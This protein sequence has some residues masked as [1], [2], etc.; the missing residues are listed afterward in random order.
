[1]RNRINA[2]VVIE[3]VVPACVSAVAALFCGSA[4]AVAA[5]PTAPGIVFFSPPTSPAF[6]VQAV[7]PVGR[8]I[9]P[10]HWISAARC[11]AGTA[12]AAVGAPARIMAGW[13]LGRLGP[14]YYLAAASDDEL[15][16]VDTIVM[17]D[18]GSVDELTGNGSCDIAV[19]INGLPV[20]RRSGQILAR[21]LAINPAAHL[22]VL[23]GPG[24]ADPA[25]RSDGR[26]HAGI[27][28]AYFDDVK[29]A[30]SG[31]RDR[32]SVCNYLSTLD[33]RSAH[34]AMFDGAAPQVAGL[35]PSSCPHIPGMTRESATPWHP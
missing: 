18:P 7:L 34:Q 16:Q 32:I 19:T 30:G 9:L 5:A 8:T 3:R 4:P 29:A 14:I 12:K 6:P 28:R 10:A 13:S 35:G 31:L 20:Y 15:R 27:Q 25:H 11:S 17:I 26:A 23:A 33:D 2:R 1:M 21:W 22:I 24:T